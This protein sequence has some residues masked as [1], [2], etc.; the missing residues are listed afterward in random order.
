MDFK[1]KS[2]DLF[3]MFNDR[4]ALVTAGTIDGYN[5]MFMGEIVDVIER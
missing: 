2:C 1:D 4:R 5:T 3:R